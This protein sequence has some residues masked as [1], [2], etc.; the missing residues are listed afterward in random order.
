MATQFDSGFASLAFA[1]T[2]TANSIVSMTTTDNTAQACATAGNAIGVL[3]QDVVSGSI[4]L[5][6]LWSPS[7]FVRNLATLVTAADKLYIG[8]NG[9]VSG[10]GTAAL[11]VAR[12]A[13]ATGDTI[14]VFITRNIAV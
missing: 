12:N 13:G 5:V 10:S 4:G 6:K 14:E 1:S 9:T 7:F 8:A 11:G 3:Q 2:V